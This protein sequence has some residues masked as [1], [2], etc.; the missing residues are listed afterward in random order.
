MV[1]YKLFQFFEILLFREILIG[2]ELGFRSVAPEKAWQEGNTLIDGRGPVVQLD[3]LQDVLGPEDNNCKLWLSLAVTVSETSSDDRLTVAQ[4]WLKS[5]RVPEHHSEE[6]SGWRKNQERDQIILNCLGRGMEPELICDQLDK[7][8]IPA[9]PALQ[10]RGI[11]R[12]ADGWGSREKERDSA[13]IFESPQAPYRCQ[14]R[15]VC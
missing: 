3:E 6:R 5:L 11:H 7:R 8:T 12:W 14:A 10:A 13:I 4:E 2:E 15:R 1:Y 9:L